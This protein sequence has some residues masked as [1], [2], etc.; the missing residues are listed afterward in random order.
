MK[1]ATTKLGDSAED[2]SVGSD[3]SVDTS[4]TEDKSTDD[5]SKDIKA[6]EGG[7][8]QLDSMFDDNLQDDGTDDSGEDTGDEDASDEDADSQDEDASS[9][10]SEEE[11]DELSLEDF[12][13]KDVKVT[14]AEKRINRL[15][16]EKRALEDRVKALESN[17]GK[18]SEPEY[19]D[20]Q[21]ASA[22]QKAIENQDYQLLSEIQSYREKRLETKLRNEYIEAQKAVVTPQKEAQK[23]WTSVLEDYAYLTDDDEDEIYK[24]SKKELNIKNPKSLFYG[25][26]NQLYVNPEK[27]ARY[28]RP[29]GMQ[30]AVAD[31]LT[32]ILRKRKGAPSKSKSTKKLEKKLAKEKR[33]STMS[34]GKQSKADKGQLSKSPTSNDVLNDY[35]KERKNSLAQKRGL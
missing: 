13:I 10:G 28:K 27:E 21:L 22:T 32:L 17:Q 1:P 26:A 4:K 2:T 14:G 30:L 31:A 29:G 12:G 15:T 35:I 11:G 3:E 33:K 19:T 5:K 20:T 23:E 18:K 7:K 24:G 8:Q 25:L 34:S 16:A 6:G 9:E